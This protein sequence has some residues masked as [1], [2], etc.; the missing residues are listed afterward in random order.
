MNE[1]NEYILY[2]LYPTNFFSLNW[3]P[4]SRLDELECVGKMDRSQ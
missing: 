1:W 3:L 2:L 4:T